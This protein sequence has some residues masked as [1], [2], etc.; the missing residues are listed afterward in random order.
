MSISEHAL[1][2]CLP[3]QCAPGTTVTEMAQKRQRHC[4]EIPSFPQLVRQPGYATSL[5]LL[6]A[7]CGAHLRGGRRA[8]GLTAAAAG[9]AAW[10]GGA[11]RVAEPGCERSERR[12]LADARSVSARTPAVSC[13][14][15]REL[16][17]VS[18]TALLG[19]VWR[20]AGRLSS[21]FLSG[22]PTMRL[23]TDK[24]PEHRQ[25]AGH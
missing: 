24:A 11:K 13:W 19:R 23:S 17:P 7:E 3:N 20:G 15:K 4:T 10:F 8:K 25:W 16:F 2:T 9:E 1:V 22:V 5:V 12:I 18:S 14:E 21:V 6:E